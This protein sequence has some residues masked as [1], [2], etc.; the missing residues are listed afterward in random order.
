M[1]QVLLIVSDLSVIKCRCFNC[2]DYMYRQT[3]KA[4]NGVI[5]VGGGG[6][7][8]FLFQGEILAFAWEELL[9][10]SHGRAV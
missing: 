7:P 9:N 10:R 2:R 6:V 1:V 4:D 3:W 8:F 5:L